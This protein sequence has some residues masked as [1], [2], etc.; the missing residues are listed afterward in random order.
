MSY[1]GGIDP[2][3]KRAGIAPWNNLSSSP[4]APQ[5]HIAGCWVNHHRS[6][7]RRFCAGIFRKLGL[8]IGFSLLVLLGCNGLRQSVHQPAISTR[9]LLIK[10]SLNLGKVVTSRILGITAPSHILAW[11]SRRLAT[12]LGTRHGSLSIPAPASHLRPGT[13]ANSTAAAAASLRQQIGLGLSLSLLKSLSRQFLLVCGIRY[14]AL[15]FQ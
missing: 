11:L 3:Q 14:P 8:I 5:R 13:T 9:I 1:P 15:V 10:V 7:G 4:A 12:S 2:V 6:L